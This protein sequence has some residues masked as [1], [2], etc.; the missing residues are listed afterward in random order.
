[1]KVILPVLFGQDF[2]KAFLNNIV[3][4]ADDAIVLGIVD[5]ERMGKASGSEL[6][7]I[8]EIEKKVE[9]IEDYL[10]RKGVNTK[11]IVQWGE[12]ERIIANTAKLHKANKVI[13]LFT[14]EDF[15]SK[16]VRNLKKDL[17]CTLD[18]V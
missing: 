13:L 6:G 9:M 1:M 3:K 15:F 5:A 16:V 4:E 12:I 14:P 17:K 10:I 2:E 11:G 18:V 7:H 8:S